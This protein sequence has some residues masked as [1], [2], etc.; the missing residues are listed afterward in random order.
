MNKKIVY[1]TM[2]LI[3]SLYGGKP[4]SRFTA[5]SPKITMRIGGQIAAQGCTSENPEI[6]EAKKSCIEAVALG[7]V[8][9]KQKDNRRT[10]KVIITV[11]E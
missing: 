4:K 6:V 7:T 1:I 11:V 2:L 9:I 5:L 3:S 10:H 8:V